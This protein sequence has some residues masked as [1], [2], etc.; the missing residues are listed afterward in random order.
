M[1]ILLLV[2]FQIE[3]Q[4]QLFGGSS[5]T[6]HIVSYGENL[7]DVATQY[8][9][10]IDAILEDNKNIDPLN[11][12]RGD[13]LVVRK[14]K[15]KEKL[16][17]SE[18][19][20]QWVRLRQEI[21][22]AAKQK[23]EQ[24]AAIPGED[25]S[26]PQ[27]VKMAQ[28]DLRTAEYKDV[29]VNA[30]LNIA[31]LLPLKGDRGVES[32]FVGLY[33]GAL[34]ALE[35]L[36]RESREIVVNVYNTSKSS[37]VVESLINSGAL[38]EVDLIIGPVYEEPFR[39]AAE[40]AAELGVPIVS[41]LATMSDIAN[42]FVFE[43]PVTGDGRYEE[44]R[45]L[46][47]AQNNVI[48]FSGSSNDADLQS[49]L[50]S[51]LPSNAR[52]VEYSKSLPVEEIE[53]LLTDETENVFVVLPSS[54]LEVDEILARLSSVQN[55]LAVRSIMKASISTIGS[56]KWLR[57]TNIDRTLFFKL[58]LHCV[59]SYHADRGNN[60]VRRFDGE[61]IEAYGSAP[62]LYAYRGYDVVKL[63]AYGVGTYGSQF[64]NYINDLDVELLQTPYEFE[65]DRSGKFTNRR[66]V[67]VRYGDDFNISV[68][69]S[70]LPQQEV[71][72]FQRVEVEEG[73]N[74]DDL[75]TAT[76]Q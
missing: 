75:N 37:T 3:S 36:K 16:T 39:V 44:L 32:Q 64:I 51:L 30:P 22:A 62:S 34:I 25:K 12:N 53:E 5:T 66:W 65:R 54:E 38:S 17:N 13:R 55:N 29:G 15:R 33:R 35:D 43:V 27:P 67:T 19:G 63:F 56:S 70:D 47:T 23:E 20:D 69:N 49:G 60:N 59:S 18:I 24:Q 50:S 68:L 7:Y 11:L 31:M 45:S 28:M 26:M 41:P 48:V 52:R 9:S 42:P 21:E 40:Y 8:G 46:L 10:S 14:L 57:F 76:E 58:K 72:D 73:E 74:G 6:T 71:Y 2:A 4:A 61:Y 1:L